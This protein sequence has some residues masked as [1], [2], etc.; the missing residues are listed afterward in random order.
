M[1][2][3]IVHKLVASFFVACLTRLC[4]QGLL[5]RK[6]RNTDDIFMQNL[7]RATP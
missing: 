1:E 3:V 4:A 2:A 6:G 5:E 7:S